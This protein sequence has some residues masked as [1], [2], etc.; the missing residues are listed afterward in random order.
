MFEWI[1]HIADWLV[2][3]VL[4]LEYGEHLS[5]ALNFFIYD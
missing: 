3:D 4:N 5:E 2:F 1:Q